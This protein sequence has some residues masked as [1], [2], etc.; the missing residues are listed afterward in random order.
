MR[1]SGIITQYHKLLL[2]SYRA[3][4]IIIKQTSNSYI[5]INKTWCELPIFIELFKDI[6]HRIV[7]YR[8]NIG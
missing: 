2:P 7:K 8:Y 3:Y 5:N 4:I 6:L 1:D